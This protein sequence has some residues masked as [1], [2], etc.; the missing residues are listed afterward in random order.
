MLAG[1]GSPTPRP[2]SSPVTIAADAMIL[3]FTVLRG[4]TT[5]PPA[6]RSARMSWRS[7]PRS[8]RVR[9]SG[10][11]VTFA[12]GRSSGRARKP[13][14][15]SRSRSRGSARTRRFRTSPT[16]ATRRSERERTSAQD[17]SRRT[18]RTAPVSQRADDDRPQRPGRRRHY[19][20]CSGHCWRR[21]VDGGRS[22]RHRRRPGEC[23]RRL[24]AQAGQQGRARWKAERLSRR[25]RAS[26]GR[27]RRR[28]RSSQSAAPCR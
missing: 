25:C 22:R 2:G 23:A 14:R 12:R 27:A 20:R 19:A 11:S 26:R 7:T 9:W 15:S 16:S 5:S 3:P 28:S 21:C 6:P 4:T 17:R 18:S 13:A 10:P 24:P 8:A 1:V